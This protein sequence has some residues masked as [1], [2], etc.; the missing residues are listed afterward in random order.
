M[1]R[2][3]TGT[4]ST[5]I[6]Q[7]YSEHLPHNLPVQK[8]GK[9]IAGEAEQAENYSE[10]MDLDA[11]MES[12]FCNLDQLANGIQPT[13]SMDMVDTLIFDKDESFVFQNIVF[14]SESKNLIIEKNM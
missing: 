13:F 8:K 10:N 3:S 11:D 1:F 6:L 4:N 7:K 5:T 2:Q 9:R 14:G 12:I